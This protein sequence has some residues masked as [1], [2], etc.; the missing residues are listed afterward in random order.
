MSDTTDK[1]R[2]IKIN[3][4]WSKKQRTL[5]ITSF[6]ND[7]VIRRYQAGETAYK[8]AKDLGAE[9]MT[10]IARLKRAGVYMGNRQNK[11]DK[12]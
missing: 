2:T 7:E 9:Q 5:R 3:E 12:Q 4:Y 1:D 8:I 11:G 6:S 10:I